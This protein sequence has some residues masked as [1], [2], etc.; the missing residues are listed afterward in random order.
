MSRKAY[1]IKIVTDEQEVRTLVQLSREFHDAYYLCAGFPS[2]VPEVEIALSFLAKDGYVIR[3]VYD[4]DGSPLAW[5]CSHKH[6]GR[7]LW[8]CPMRPWPE[9]VVPGDLLSPYAE[10]VDAVEWDS[11]TATVYGEVDNEPLH[12]LFLA[13]SGFAQRE[14]NRTFMRRAAPHLPYRELRKGASIDPRALEEWYQA[15]PH[16]RPKWP[17]EYA[18][19][20]RP[21]AS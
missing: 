10:L 2:A 15:H 7:G 12:Q 17:H 1:P 6:D 19:P 9:I 3:C 14:G 13:S 21:L 11:D 18:A 20:H 16:R 8:T 4:H 5:N